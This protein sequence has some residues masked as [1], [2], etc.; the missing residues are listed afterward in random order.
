MSLYGS[1][2]SLARSSLYAIGGSG[3]AQLMLIVAAPIL[4]RL[5]TPEEFGIFAIYVAIV[6]FLSMGIFLK[7]EL[8]IPIS[9]SITSTLSIL[10]LCLGL[11]ALI[12]F[13]IL[14]ALYFFETEFR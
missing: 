4:T 1:K 13:L 12:G 11:G 3:G 9:Q 6:T 8:A 14:V 7:Y 10:K 5:F 2:L